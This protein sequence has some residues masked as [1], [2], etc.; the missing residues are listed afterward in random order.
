MENPKYN[1]EKIRTLE[2]HSKDVFFIFKFIV[3]SNFIR[4]NGV[5]F[6]LMEN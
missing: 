3:I 2:G 4:L 5:V 1:Y 6:H